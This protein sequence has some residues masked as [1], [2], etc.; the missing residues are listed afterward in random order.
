MGGGGGAWKDNANAFSN[1][2]L[3]DSSFSLNYVEGGEGREGSYITVPSY[4]R[5]RCS[6]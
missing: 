3:L 2:A 6:R 4:G 1:S 5:G